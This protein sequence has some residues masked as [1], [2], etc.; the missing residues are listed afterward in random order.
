MKEKYRINTYSLKINTISKL[1]GLKDKINLS[2]PYQRQGDL[3]DKEK[4]ELFL[5]SIFNRYDVPKIY[6]HVL[7][8]PYKKY[9]YSVIDGRQRLETIW[10][11]IDD[12]KDTRIG[13]NEIY[14][15]NEVLELK[16]YSYSDLAKKYPRLRT[17][18][19]TRELP[20]V[21]V[22]TLDDTEGL[23]E[24]M[25]SRL[26]E[27]VSIN[28]AEKRN[29]KTG[30]MIKTVRKIAEHEFF[31]KK[32]SFATKR[33]QNHEIAARLLFIENCIF[34]GEIK[35][36][37]KKFLDDFVED[38]K[39]SLPDFPIKDDV[40]EILDKMANN[41]DDKDPMLKKQGK[42]LI[43]YL[44]YREAIHDNSLRR[45]SRDSLKEFD[46]KVTQNKKLEQAGS[47]SAKFDLGQYDRASIQGTNDAGSIKLRFEIMAKHLGIRDDRITSL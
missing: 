27:A 18:F 7:E 16:G 37:K 1:Y 26:N 20:I 15:E 32:I 35:D 14:F 45:V 29:S 44:L 36:T 8:K 33:M 41:F 39:E 5:D 43:Y 28:A 22:E 13:E 34:E 3:W 31:S 19:D 40:L 12:D 11:F 30:K 24:D 21:G 23:I 2:P 9:Q 46:N 47:K 42:I 38:H 17:Y 10:K 6:F 4:K 25:F